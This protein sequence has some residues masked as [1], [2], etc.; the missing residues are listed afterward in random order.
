MS[1]IRCLLANNMNPFMGRFA[2][3]VASSRT[4]EVD[5]GFWTSLSKNVP[6]RTLNEYIN[7]EKN[8]CYHLIH[9]YWNISGSKIPDSTGF[10]TFRKPTQ[11][12]LIRKTK[13]SMMSFSNFGCH[14]C[15]FILRYV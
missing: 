7:F 10:R 11:I 5:A 14:K 1:S 4:G 2:F 9:K 13:Q 8:M 3:V 15:F 6:F 12:G